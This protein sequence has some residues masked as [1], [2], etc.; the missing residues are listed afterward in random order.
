[1]RFRVYP[2]AVWIVFY[3]AEDLY[4]L[5]CYDNH[6]LLLSLFNTDDLIGVG[7]KLSNFHPIAIKK[8]I[9]INSA[10]KMNISAAIIFLTSL[11]GRIEKR[12]YCLVTFLAFISIFS[13]QVAKSEVVIIK[14]CSSVESE[15]IK[16][17]RKMLETIKL[18]LYRE[19]TPEKNILGEITRICYEKNVAHYPALDGVLGWTDYRDG[20]IEGSRDRS[21]NFV[22]RSAGGQFARG[23]SDGYYNRPKKSDPYSSKTDAEKPPFE[24]WDKKCEEVVIPKPVDAESPRMKRAK[25]MV[26]ELRIRF[27]ETPN[28][29]YNVTIEMN[30]L[31]DAEKVCRKTK[32]TRGE[33]ITL[34]E[35]VPFS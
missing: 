26:E 23:Y 22:P 33:E 7:I 6:Y 29:Y 21:K 9:H 11:S 34:C 19:I 28:S 4:Y 13:S 31:D 15:S 10:N 30:S 8:K 20:H 27:R 12:N 14:E 24:S 1:M 35:N 18:P 3:T 17:V 25:K 32:N 16:E 5:I 2:F